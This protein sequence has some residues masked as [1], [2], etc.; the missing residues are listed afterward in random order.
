MTR[1][2]A[3]A[4]LVARDVQRWGEP[5]RAASLRLR[6]K[7]THGLA[8]NA[9]AYYDIDSIDAGLATEAEAALTAEDWRVLRGEAVSVSRWR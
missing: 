1:D 9:L 5:E 4:E 2:Q 8:L 3:V 7:L 6:N